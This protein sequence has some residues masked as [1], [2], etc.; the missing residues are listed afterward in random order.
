M[1]NEIRWICV[2]T[3]YFYTNFQMLRFWADFGF[4]VLLSY[5]MYIVVEAPSGGLELLL[6]LCGK[7]KAAATPAPIE[8]RLKEDIFTEN[9]PK[10][11]TKTPIES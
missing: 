9:A 11:V 6:N 7:P 10:L 8:P 4:T 1:H 5:F 2:I 3:H